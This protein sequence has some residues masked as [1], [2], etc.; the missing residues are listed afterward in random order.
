MNPSDFV[1]LIS[2]N[3]KIGLVGIEIVPKLMWADFIHRLRAT[4]VIHMP[5][6]AT[7][8]LNIADVLKE[9]SVVDE[10]RRVHAAM[11]FLNNTRFGQSIIG[12][13]RAHTDRYFQLNTQ[14]QTKLHPDCQVQYCRSKQC[15]YPQSYP[16]LYPLQ[17]HHRQ[18]PQY[19]QQ[20]HPQQYHHYAQQYHP[21]QYHYPHHYPQYPHQYHPQQLQVE[22]KAHGYFKVIPHGLI[23]YPTANHSLV[24]IGTERDGKL[25]KLTPREQD[26]ARKLGIIP[27][28]N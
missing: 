5:Y 13:L 18:Y 16:K 12:Q 11:I 7:K 15:C 28:C 10:S 24:A 23:I 22:K 2:T 17:Y 8:D 26:M 27:I 21:Q 1:C 3:S 14:T 6:D 4:N 9:I 20:Y 25:R 19:P